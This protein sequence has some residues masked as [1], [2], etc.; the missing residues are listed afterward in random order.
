M[1]TCSAGSVIASPSSCAGRPCSSAERRYGPHYARSGHRARAAGPATDRRG[2]RPRAGAADAGVH[3]VR[4]A[5]PRRHRPRRCAR[6]CRRRPRRRTRCRT[7][8]TWESCVRELW[9]AAAFR[10]E[11]YAALALA[12]HRLY[13][14]CQDPATLPLFRHLVVTGAWWDL[15][16]PVASRGVGGVLGRPPGRGHAGAAGVGRGRRPVAAAY[17]DHRPAAPQGGHRPRPAPTRPSR[18]TWRAPRTAASSS[19]AR[20]SAGRCGSTPASTPSGC[21]RSSPSTRNGSPA[22]Q[23]RGAQAPVTRRFGRET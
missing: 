1:C 3:E 21:G 8:T 12:S 18:R 6:C 9:D 20:R 7:A 14:A 19:S 16:D 23:A 17:G 15:V 22:C 2:R 10:E 13:R 4:D 11:R 5:L